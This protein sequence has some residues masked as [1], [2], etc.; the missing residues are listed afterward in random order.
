PQWDLPLGPKTGCRGHPG[1]LRGMDHP[2]RGIPRPQDPRAGPPSSM[3]VE[4]GEVSGNEAGAFTLEGCVES[5]EGAVAAQEGGA[6]RVELCA[7]LLEGG[8]TPSA[9]TIE[10]VRKRI[11]IDLN[12]MIRPRGG[13]FCY[14]AAELETLRADVET[15]KRLGAD[16]VVF[17]ILRE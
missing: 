13:D 7:S 17:G 3:D 2:P 16:G 6:R 15:S 9:G 8:I 12:V 11:Q 14:S 5:V 1:D 4:A 10:R